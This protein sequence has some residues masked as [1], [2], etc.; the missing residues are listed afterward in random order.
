MFCQVCEFFCLLLFFSVNLFSQ[1][2][3]WYTYLVI[4]L[5]SNTVVNHFFEY[6]LYDL[7]TIYNCILITHFI[8][9]CKLWMW[10]FYCLLLLFKYNTYRKQYIHEIRLVAHFSCHYNC[11]PANQYDFSR[12]VLSLLQLLG[13]A[14]NNKNIDYNKNST[15]MT[16]MNETKCLG[17]YSDFNTMPK[18]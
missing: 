17:Y 8:L 16:K 15:W 14:F 2:H 5:E 13:G 10:N 6:N 12:A 3:L 18:L 11:I 7:S 1:F 9:C 4:L